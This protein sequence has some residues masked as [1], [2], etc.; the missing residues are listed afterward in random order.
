MRT[1]VKS[2]F[3]ASLFLSLC[4]AIAF[5]QEKDTLT[6]VSTIDALLSGIYDGKMPVGE[7]KK[8]GDFGIGTFNGLDGEMIAMDG[9]FYQIDSTGKAVEVGNDMKTPYS[10]VTFFAADQSVVLDT[11]VNYDSLRKQLDKAIP[12]TNIFYAIKIE[13]VFKAIKARSVPKQSKPY[14]LPKEIVKTQPIFNY[15]SVEGTMIGFRCPSYVKG[16]NVPGYHFHFLK[17]DGTAGGHV[18]EFTIGKAV[19]KI[20]HTARFSMI[21]PDN[22]ELYSTDFSGDKAAELKK[23][24]K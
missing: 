13:G 24:I 21:L 16:I 11:G 22:E 12:T 18:L 23:V 1:I 10:A 15:E 8:L 17:K 2:F 5:A 7:L 9:R 6:Q 19:A 4:C 14:K 3:I 20:D